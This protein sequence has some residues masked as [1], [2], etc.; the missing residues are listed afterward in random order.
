MT[1]T[2]TI[3]AHLSYEKEVGVTVREGDAIFEQF[4]LQDGE[5]ESRVVFD[6][7]TITVSEVMKT[8]H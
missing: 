8:D 4:T 6:D 2:V 1:T 5:S 7:R 3:A